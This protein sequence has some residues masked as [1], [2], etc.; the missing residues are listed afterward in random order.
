MAVKP[1]LRSRAWSK[2]PQRVASAAFVAVAATA[3]EP[4]RNPGAN[5]Y[6]SGER[7]H[8][9][10]LY[11]GRRTMDEPGVGEI[12]NQLVLGGEYAYEDPDGPFGIEVGALAGVRGDEVNGERVHGFGRELYAGLRKSVTLGA[13]RPYV[14]AGGTWIRYDLE[15][16]GSL[17]ENDAS[18]AWYARGGI[19]LPLDVAGHLA[20]DVR[21]VFGTS[22]DFDAFDATGD[23][24]Q[25]A[26]LLG[27]D[28]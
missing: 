8:H 14:G 9:A 12:E 22:M 4:V 11:V 15:G 25:V 6:D 18:S 20:L 27:V 3:C 17:E 7:S 28:F 2:T 19:A 5:R 1:G 26:L 24:V 13:I 21:R 23:Y 16:V 10:A